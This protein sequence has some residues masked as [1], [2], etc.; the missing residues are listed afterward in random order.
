MPARL[1]LTIATAVA[2]L[3]VLAVVSVRSN[4]PGRREVVVA[5]PSAPGLREGSPVT[6]LGVDAGAVKRIDL[7]TG[8]AVV[9]L[10]IRRSDVVLRAD[11]VVRLRIVGLLGDEVVDIMPGPRSA[12]LV[13]ARDTLV[14][15][16]ERINVLVPS[17]SFDSALARLLGR[18]DT[19]RRRDASA[20]PAAPSRP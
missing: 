20:A 18:G 11:D 16:P 8:R 5:L 14:V 4:A 12:R 7:S 1:G 3:V 10:G 17:S 13:T 9:T 15:P 6:Y 19:A 2:L